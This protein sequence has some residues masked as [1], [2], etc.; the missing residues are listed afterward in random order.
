MKRS[1]LLLGL[2]LLA[3]VAGAH[4]QGT[5]AFNNFSPFKVRILDSAGLPLS[6]GYWV[7]VVVKDPK[8]GE[9]RGGLD[10][11]TT[12]G[13]EPFVRAAVLT[14]ANAG[15]FNGGT[16]RV[17]FIA[18]GSPAVLRVR[19]WGADSATFEKATV[20]GQVEFALPALG[21]VPDP[22]TGIAGLGTPIVPSFTGL[23]VVAR[24][25][26]QEL[27]IRMV[28]QGSAVF[29]EWPVIPQP[30]MTWMGYSFACERTAEDAGSQAHGRQSLFAGA[31]D[32]TG[33]I[34][35]GTDS[36]PVVVNGRY[37]LPVDLSSRPAGFF[38]VF[39]DFCPGCP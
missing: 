22:V 12:T 2:P 11:M 30:P 34:F 24:P 35:L 16:L 20:A 3:V 6:G 39:V 7:D 15:V 23:V 26:S 5:I 25:S 9:F 29:L 32:G 36:V 18:P 1:H 10:R 28:R 37:R 14:G 4:A 19:A 38:R 21:G 27:A 8:T 17:P 31:R 13:S 33:P